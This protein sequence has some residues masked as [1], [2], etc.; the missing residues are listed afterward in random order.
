MTV[1]VRGSANAEE[2]AAVVAVLSRPADPLPSGYERWRAGRIAALR[3]S[4]TTV[5]C[6]SR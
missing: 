2:L 3:T 4:T 6:T 1:E 5:R